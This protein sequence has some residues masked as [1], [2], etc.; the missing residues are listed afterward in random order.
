MITAAVLGVAALTASES[1]YIE[2]VPSKTVVDSKELFAINVYVN[3]HVPVNAVN[4]VLNFPSNQLEVFSIDTGES[5]ITIWTEEPHAEGSKVYFS[6]GT[7]RKG[8][9]GKHLIGT[10]NFLP[11]TSGNFVFNVSDI[12]LLAGDGAGSTVSVSD[13]GVQ[14]VKVYAT[15]EDGVIEGDVDFKVVTDIDGDGKVTLSDISR[16]MEAWRD[17]SAVFDFNKD[18]RMT[19][20]DFAIILA[21]SFFK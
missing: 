14:T 10:V 1:S 3:A 2:L 19:F 17:G 21:D 20:V 11:K 8:F 9:L 13:D 4:V 6:G 18:G 12:I 5:V 7:F 15:N 16:F